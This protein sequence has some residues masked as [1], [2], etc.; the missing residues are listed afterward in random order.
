MPV[1]GSGGSLIKFSVQ[2]F[3]WIDCKVILESVCVKL[4][5]MSATVC[6][7]AVRARGG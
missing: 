7:R 6:E 1:V 3:A 4:A 2:T 5:Q